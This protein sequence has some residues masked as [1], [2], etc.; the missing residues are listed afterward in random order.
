MGLLFMI[1]DFWVASWFTL[2]IFFDIGHEVGQK[3]ANL[4]RDAVTVAIF[5]PLPQFDVVAPTMQFD[6]ELDLL[7]WK[8]A[9]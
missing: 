1:F 5:Q 2:I 9:N 6:A 7:D 8:F 4:G 3:L